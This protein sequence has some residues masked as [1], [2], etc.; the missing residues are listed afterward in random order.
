MAYTLG[1]LITDI[2]RRA[3]D[4]SFSTALITSYINDTQN[5]VVGEKRWPFLEQLDVTILPVGAYSYDYE[6]D[7][8]TTYD[9]TLVDPDG[10]Q[11]YTQPTFL[12]H[13]HFFDQ[14]PVPEAA[15][16]SMPNF[17][18]DFGRTMMFDCPADKAYKLRVRYLAAPT[19]LVNDS[20]TPLIPQEYK[21]IL[22]RGALA[23]IE[24]YRDNYDLGA[25]HRR[26]VE[27][28]TAD[29]A[30]RYMLRQFQAAPKGAPQ[31]VI[32]RAGF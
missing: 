4:T 21:E 29:M 18:T 13:T 24:E 10:S 2:Q 19:E 7:A 31:R 16:Q 5:E 26:K 20:D 23:A 12:P 22:I 25:V 14:F 11:N 17:W 1:D 3:K 28:L 27:D 30:K 8:Q 15:N 32:R 6:S 9:V